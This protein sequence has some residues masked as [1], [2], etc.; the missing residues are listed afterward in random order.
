MRCDCVC[1]GPVAGETVE[2]TQYGEYRARGRVVQNKAGERDRGQALT[3]GHGKTVWG[4]VGHGRVICLYPTR[5]GNHW[6]L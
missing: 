6:K 2:A 1:K 4:L 5:A 3:W